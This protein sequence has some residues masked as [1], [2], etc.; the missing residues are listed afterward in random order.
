[1]QASA[2][3]GI[4]LSKVVLGNPVES[5]DYDAVGC[6]IS[7]RW[8]KRRMHFGVCDLYMEHFMGSAFWHITCRL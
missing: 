4:H 6:A 1:V 2:T 7:R 3:I 5:M 8:V